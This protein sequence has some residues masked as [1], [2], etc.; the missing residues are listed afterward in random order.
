[1][2]NENRAKEMEI[3]AQ[4]LRIEELKELNRS[5]EIT[6]NSHNAEEKTRQASVD[7]C[8]NTNR[9]L[10]GKDFRSPSLGEIVE[11]CQAQ[12]TNPASG[13]DMQA[14]GS[15]T[16]SPQAS[17]GEI[18]TGL[19]LGGGALALVLVIAAKRGSRPTNA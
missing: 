17:S 1:A 12:Y 15:A 6:R 5:S 2:E 19:L 9:N 3:Q 14:A 18:N 16:A 8:V 7:S 13:L 11:D 10:I 4:L